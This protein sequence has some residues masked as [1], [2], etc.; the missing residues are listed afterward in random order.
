MGIDH[1]NP[2]MTKEAAKRY[3]ARAEL[4]ALEVCTV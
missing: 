1:I 3:A 2:S 4:P